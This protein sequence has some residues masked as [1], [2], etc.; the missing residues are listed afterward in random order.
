MLDEDDTDEMDI[1]FEVTRTDGDR[2]WA[3][4]VAFPE[5]ATYSDFIDA[6]RIFLDSE[7]AEATEGDPRH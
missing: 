3:L 5:L 7:E 2:R 1:A 4:K 6:V